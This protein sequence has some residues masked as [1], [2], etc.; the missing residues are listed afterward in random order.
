VHGDDLEIVPGAAQEVDRDRA[1]AERLAD[2]ARDLFEQLCSVFRAAR[3]RGDL[4]EGAK[5]REG[6]R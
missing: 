2:R 4:E 6:V 3:K 1:I 5:A